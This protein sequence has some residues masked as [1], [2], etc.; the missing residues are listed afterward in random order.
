MLKA[1]GLRRMSNS[2][3]CVGDYCVCVDC[4]IFVKWKIMQLCIF[5]KS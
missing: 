3:D 4:N 2:N 1:Q 5:E